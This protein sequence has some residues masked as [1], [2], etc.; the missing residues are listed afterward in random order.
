MTNPAILLAFGFGPMEIG[1]IL[2]ACVFLFGAKKLPMIGDGL[3]KGIKNF[4]KSLKGEDDDTKTSPN[5]GQIEGSNNE[6]NE[7]S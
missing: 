7:D 3:G 6:D 2:L 5:S 4:R 1:L